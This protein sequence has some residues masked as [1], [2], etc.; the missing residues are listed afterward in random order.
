LTTASDWARF[1]IAWLEGDIVSQATLDTMGTF[2]PDVGLGS[3]GMAFDGYGYGVF[4]E[5]TAVDTF[6]AH[7]GQGYGFMAFF[8]I[9]AATKTGYVVMTNSQR[10]YPMIAM[11]S[12]GLYQEEHAGFPSIGNIHRLMVG[13]EILIGG[14]L[15]GLAVL[16]W[17]MIHRRWLQ[18]RIVFV[19]LGLLSVATLGFLM[20]FLRGNYL[21]LHVLIPIHFEWLMG[22]LGM[23][24]LVVL[25]GLGLSVP[26]TWSCDRS[27]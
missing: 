6:L 18:H 20:Y 2:D 17:R 24:S 5:E 15:F 11:L 16:L 21:F 13:M 3:Y 26:S 14:L 22:V 4:V 8:H 19:V 9:D 23:G 7:G 10:T 27:K 12:R 25:V 1:L